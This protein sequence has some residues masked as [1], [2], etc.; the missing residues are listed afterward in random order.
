MRRTRIG[1]IAL[2]GGLLLASCGSDSEESSDTTAAAAEGD[3]AGGDPAACA[4]GKTLEDGKLRLATGDPA[5]PPYVIDDA[6]ESGEGFEAAVA[7]A[8]AEQMGFAPDSVAWVRTTFDEAIQ[9]GPKSFDFN[10][11]QYTI[12]AERAEIVSFSD[13]YYTSAQAILGFEDSPAATATTLD[14]LKQLKLGAAAATTSLDFIAEQ[15]QPDS[16]PFVFNDNAAAKQALESK[17]IDAIVTDLPTALF[18]T[19]VEIEGSKVFGQFPAGDGQGDELGMLFSKD[20][21]LVE[22][23]NLALGALSASGEL[24]A[25]TTTWMSEYTEA[26]V[27]A[28]G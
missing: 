23:V 8:V 4:E 14:A 25:I 21:P 9:P 13:P 22:C 6:P 3:S 17:Q 26:P 18:I 5:F 28:L 15:I 2:A 10:I 24:E 12:N 20:N 16:E 19:G 7:M 11:Q 27:I 1:A